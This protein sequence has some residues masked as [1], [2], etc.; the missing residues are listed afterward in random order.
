[1]AFLRS[2]NDADIRPVARGGGVFVRPP[3]MSDYAAWAEMRA[4]SREYLAPWEPTWSRD[5]LTRGAFRQR[6]RHYARE[7]REGTGYAFFVLREGDAAFLGGLSLSNVRRGV[8]QS[9]TIGYWVGRPHANQ[10]HMT[11]AVSAINPFVFDLLALHRLEAACLPS[12]LASI[13]VLERTGFECEGLARSY[14]KINGKW[15]DHLLYARLR[16][17]SGRGEA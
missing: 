17:P 8:T 2:S 16:E 7:T 14:L 6:L 10:G 12:N 11:A 5:E 13:K 15:Q 4:L 3:Q 9:A 1:M